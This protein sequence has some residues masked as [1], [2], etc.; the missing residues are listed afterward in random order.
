MT[1]AS[2][3]PTNR[4]VAILRLAARLCSAS[5]GAVM[6][7]PGR[8][9]TSLFCA[10][11]PQYRAPRTG[12]SAAASQAL[13]TEG[14]AAVSNSPACHSSVPSWPSAFGRDLRD[15]S[16][17]GLMKQQVLSAVTRFKLPSASLSRS[18][19]SARSRAAGAGRAPMAG[20]VSA[21]GSTPARG[22]TALSSRPI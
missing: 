6:A 17:Y 18:S 8:S 16:C 5:E 13:R 9:R 19:E 11:A 10:T 14:F 7:D 21:G 12:S 4:R 15:A 20:L 1:S 2:L 22:G 3:A